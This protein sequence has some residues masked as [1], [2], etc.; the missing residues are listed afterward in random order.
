MFGCYG[1]KILK[2]RRPINQ[3]FKT[4]ISHSEQIYFQK[5]IEGIGKNS[6]FKETAFDLG[7]SSEILKK[8]LKPFSKQFFEK[9]NDEKFYNSFQNAVE[10]NLEK[11][12]LEKL[13]L[14]FILYA[15]E[16]ES[17]NIEMISNILDLSNPEDEFQEARKL[18]R[19]IYFH[20]GPTNSGKSFSSIERLSASE[21]GVYC[22]PLRFK[23]QLNST[24][25]RLLATEVYTKLNSKGVKCSLMTGEIK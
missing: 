24:I 12:L 18:Q 22:S 10:K 5:M 9:Y 2:N 8:S 19:K 20:T 25:I 1:A 14:K 3:F 13:F 17:V 23:I 6:N 11:D 15:H 21:N 7:I 16:S 4:Y